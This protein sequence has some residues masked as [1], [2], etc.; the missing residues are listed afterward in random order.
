MNATTRFRTRLGQVRRLPRYGELVRQR[1]ATPY[2]GWV[3]E[4]NLG[5]EAMYLAHRHL[6][7]E[8]RLTSLPNVLSAGPRLV[9]GMPWLTCPAVCL[10]GGTLVGNGHFRQTFESAT[11][12]W[13][14]VPMFALGVGVEDPAYETGRR[15]GV[16]A[17]IEAWRALLGRFG[18][19]SV[20]GPRSRDVL[21]SIGID[22]AVVGDSALSLP[23]IV[24]R[25]RESGLVGVNVGVVDE[26]W[27]DD[28]EG[29]RAWIGGVVRSLVGRGHR[30][31]FVS[32]SGP[33]DE[34]MRELAAVFA[35]G[36]EVV[37]AR[38]PREAASHLSRCEVLVAH[39]LHAAI[40][41]AAV[42]VP[43]IAL[44]YR[45]KCRD[46][47]ESVDRGGFVMRTDALDADLL[48]GWIDDAVRDH[49]R[50]S[51]ALRER[52]VALQGS[53]ARAGADISALVA[54]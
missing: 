8:L 52:V 13:R 45:P 27:G 31:L 49:P 17:E 33:D 46:F 35:P 11:A 36:S 15:A 14:G 22:A 12:A 3:G 44:E 24:R 38:D 40:L 32:T 9:A 4:R 47:Q 50:Q 1:Y 2:V 16:T 18:H 10:G 20:R 53:L 39:K 34:Y 37:P 6:L 51:A 26:Q 30:I 25:E 41:A 19:L 42:D 23:G 48:L 5:D 54:R 21:A 43:A 7:P 28:V 29:F